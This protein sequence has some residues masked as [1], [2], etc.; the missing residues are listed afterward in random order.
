MRFL[1]LVS[2]GRSAS[3]CTDQ[4]PSGSAQESVA[5]P[6][7]PSPT[8][9]PATAAAPSAPRKRLRRAAA[10]SSQWRPTL[11]VI[12]ENGVFC[13]VATTKQKGGR[14]GPAPQARKAKAAPVVRAS[15]RGLDYLENF[16]HFT[17]PSFIPA[18]VPAA[19][20]F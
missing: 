17:A 5:A 4:A 16:R 10:G 7:S 13:A 20:L 8:S 12:S 14:E 19:F 15:R 6:A 18:F 11:G 3:R 9:G 1:G 2:C